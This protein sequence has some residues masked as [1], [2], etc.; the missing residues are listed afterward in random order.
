MKHHCVKPCK[1]LYLEYFPFATPKAYTCYLLSIITQITCMYIMRSFRT[2]M[3]RAAVNVV[4][5]HF[6]ALFFMFRSNN[7]I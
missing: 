5:V 7:F 6:K 4:L 1:F 2:Y 3:Y